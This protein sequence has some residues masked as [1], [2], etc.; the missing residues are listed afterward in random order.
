MQVS[1]T[2]GNPS[3]VREWRIGRAFFQNS[4]FSIISLSPLSFRDN[5]WFSPQGNIR[6]HEVESRWRKLKNSVSLNSD[7]KTKC[8]PGGLKGLP[9]RGL[10]I[11]L[12]KKKVRHASKHFPIRLINSTIN[13][14]TIQENR[15]ISCVTQL[16]KHFA[17]VMNKE[18]R[19]FSCGKGH[20]LSV[21]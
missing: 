2:T 5:F 11:Y 12:E 17:N 9:G 16:N 1:R 15:F 19:A 21:T 20:H 10:S 8:D 4:D 6:I 14:F 18:R 13:N 3:I 7:E